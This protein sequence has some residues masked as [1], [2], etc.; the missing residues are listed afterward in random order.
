ME[1]P[2]FH[3]GLDPITGSLWLSN[4]ANHHL[5]TA[6]LF[7]ID[8]HMYRTN[9]GIRHGIKDI[10]EAHNGLFTCMGSSRFPIYFLVMPVSLIMDISTACISAKFLQLLKLVPNVAKP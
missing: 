6:I 5:A 3:G 8:D 7:L 10:L 4:I 9:W 1:F 2:S